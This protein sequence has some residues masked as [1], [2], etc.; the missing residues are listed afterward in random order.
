MRSGTDELHIAL[1]ILVAADRLVPFLLSA[2]ESDPDPVP[3]P[4]S[5]PDPEEE[6][7]EELPELDPDPDPDDDEPD[8]DS[9]PD[10]ETLRGLPPGPLDG[11]GIPAPN[12]AAD[13]CARAGDEVVGA[14][15]FTT[16]RADGGGGILIR[17][18]PLG[19]PVPAVFCPPA[20][21]APGFVAIKDDDD[22]DDDG[23]DGGGNA[24]DENAFGVTAGG[25]ITGVNTSSIS[26]SSSSSSSPC[27]PSCISS[28]PPPPISLNTFSNSF[29]NSI[30]SSSRTSSS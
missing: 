24:G 10:D 3:D 26:S 23:N 29:S 21:S 4:E 8:P 5:E 9:L 28:S 20:P 19:F 16:A 15:D 12:P 17:G 18:R 25:I 27:S 2:S 13:P 30:K 11:G 22:D 1:V 6:L 7:P 14:A